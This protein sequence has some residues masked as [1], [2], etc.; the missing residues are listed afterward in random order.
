MSLG[1]N[2]IWHFLQKHIYEFPPENVCI[3]YPVWKCKKKL[4]I[5]LIFNKAS[6]FVCNDVK[7]RKSS[8]IGHGT[9]IIK[10]GQLL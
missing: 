7:Y 2:L 4:D 10:I 8:C 9:V 1:H 3:Y 5:F 6:I